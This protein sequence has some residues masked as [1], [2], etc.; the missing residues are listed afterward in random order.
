MENCSDV[1][2]ITMLACKLSA[3]LSE[4]ELERLS[5]DLELLSDAIGAILVRKAQNCNN[6]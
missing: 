1:V 5:A 2:A 6:E 3:Y 4:E